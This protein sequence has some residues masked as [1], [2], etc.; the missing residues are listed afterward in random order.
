MKLVGGTFLMSAL[1]DDLNVSV[2]TFHSLHN[3][4]VEYFRD[5]V[6]DNGVLDLKYS[7]IWYYEN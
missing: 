6:D 4:L 5:I 7:W 2:W 1:L 3:E